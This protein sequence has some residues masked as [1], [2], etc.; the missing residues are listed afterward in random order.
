[1]CDCRDCEEDRI[2]KRRSQTC[3]CRKCEKPRCN[4]E[5]HQHKEE[6]C[7]KYK[8]EKY[9]PDKCSDKNEKII[10]ITIT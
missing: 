9:C 2:I 4:K 3:E 8:E 10:I 1:M 5:R 7:C 6:K